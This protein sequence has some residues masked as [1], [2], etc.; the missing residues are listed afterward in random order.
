MK[1]QKT[2]IT[3]TVTIL[4]M[5]TL[6]SLSS[7][8]KDVK[9]IDAN[10]NNSN[11]HNHAPFTKHDASLT[12]YYGPPLT[13]TALGNQKNNPYT[14]ANMELA[15]AEIANLGFTS[16]NPINVRVTHKYV[17]FTPQT[18][19]ELDI[20]EEDKNLLLYDYPLD[21]KIIEN[22]DYYRDPIASDDQPT[23]YYASVPASYSF[24]PQVSYTVLADLY[25]PEEDQTLIG[26]NLDQ[27][28]DYL[29]HLL[30]KA[31]ELTSN[32]DDVLGLNKT[33]ASRYHPAGQVR[34]FDT[35]LSA[36]VGVQGAKACARRWFTT[37]TAMTGSNGSYSMSGT[38]RRPCHQTIL[39]KE[40]TNKF[41]V[42]N[43]WLS[44][45]KYTQSKTRSNFNANL[46]NGMY[47]AFAAN[48]FRAA[49]RVCWKSS[50]STGMLL[51]QQLS[52]QNVLIA[53]NSNNA[54]PG[55]NYVIYPYIKISRYDG[56]NDEYLSDEIFS[57]T[58]HEIAHSL[59][60]SNMNTAIQYA[61][62]SSMIQESFCVGF[63]W[64][65]TRGEYNDRGIPDY[66]DEAY[67][68]PSGTPSMP[69][70]QYPNSYAYQYWN[71]SEAKYTSLFINLIDNFDE[72]NQPF[73]F[74]GNGT[75][76]DQVAGYTLNDIMDNVLKHSYGITSL[77]TELKANKPSGV[78][79]AQIDLLLSHY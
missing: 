71:A 10:E 23:Y 34:V 26:N 6:F 79:D 15:V 65:V 12:P 58:A 42:K 28:L 4:I 18:Y 36:F 11:N 54:G 68:P 3:L 45:A 25:I 69:A 31:Y 19:D 7:C 46:T 21:Y 37:K 77:A 22:G 55:V 38:F 24:N 53:K 40:F 49:Y 33:L 74:R 73:A 5:T 27:N 48:I 9:I 70:P 64:I 41:V 29:D 52:N 13:P 76:E 51:P 78:T 67:F 66:A 75:V 32:F 61:Q 35:R 60:V 63:E 44:K 14:L 20:L 59:H 30:D 47:H 57:T 50:V 72:F 8:K 62:V 56:N 1:R 43:N 39:F 16:N 17:K 2:N